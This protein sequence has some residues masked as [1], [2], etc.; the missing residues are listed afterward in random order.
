MNLPAEWMKVLDFPSVHF[1]ATP[2]VAGS[3]SPVHRLQ[4]VFVPPWK[5]GEVIFRAD[6][7]WMLRNI[8][9]FP[10]HALTLMETRLARRM[11]H[12]W[13]SDKFRRDAW[14]L[15]ARMNERRTR[16][17]FVSAL[18]IDNHSLV[19]W[20]ENALFP[21]EVDWQTPFERVLKGVVLEP[22]KTLTLRV[23]NG[24]QPLTWSV[25]LLGL[26]PARQAEAERG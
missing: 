11:K 18:M 1:A 23:R 10:S 2:R 21:V 13:R 17:T 16:G 3:V 9:L 4:H 15:M 24:C 25:A 8:C 22:S 5:T 6:Q 19:P 20:Q 12:S 7:T 14:A 26:E